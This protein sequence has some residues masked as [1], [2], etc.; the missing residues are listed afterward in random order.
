MKS[1]GEHVKVHKLK[2]LMGESKRGILAKKNITF[3]VVTTQ[4]SCVQA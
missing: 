1:K 4:V 2:S 3:K